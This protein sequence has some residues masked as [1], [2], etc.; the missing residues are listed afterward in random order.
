MDLKVEVYPDWA[1]HLV[2]LWEEGAAVGVELHRLAGR[3]H[4]RPVDHLQQ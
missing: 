1:A 3:E 4:P 2:G